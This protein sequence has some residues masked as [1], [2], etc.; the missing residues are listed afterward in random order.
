MHHTIYL[1]LMS[2]IYFVYDALFIYVCIHSKDDH[3]MARLP[4]S[5]FKSCT[6]A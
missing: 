3:N 2:V 6:G 1:L 5:T 4:L